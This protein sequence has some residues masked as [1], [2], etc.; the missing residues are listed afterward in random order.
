MKR[1]LF[2][3]DFS[4]NSLNAFVYA[5][6]LAHSLKA[7]IVTLHTYDYP[8]PDYMG[9]PIFL[10]DIYQVTDLAEFENYKGHIPMLRELAEQQRLENVQVS[11]VLEYG[12]LVPT[13]SALHQKEP[14]DY[15]VM[16]TK[17]AT[18]WAETFL[19]SVTRRVINDAQVP[20][21]V[22]PEQARFA[23]FRKFLFITGYAPEEIPV[24][25]KVL[26]LA[27]IYHAQVD[28][29][30]V[31]PDHTTADNMALHEWKTIFDEPYVR[32]HRL[33][34]RDIEG[35]VLDFI[36]LHQIDIL[37]MTTHHRNFFERLFQ[38]SLSEKFVYHAQLPMFTV[39]V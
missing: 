22:V 21:F 9:A 20:V 13:I 37:A 18:G 29:L 26:A 30:Y 36:E 39:M 32:F 27:N 38:T 3:T 8:Q 11:H 31:K 35:S 7:E 25:K 19:G 15:I 4:Q 24:F 33:H 16:G 14:F 28:C 12:E 6:K 23:P 5:L 34:S 10:P 17:G 2:P 1:I